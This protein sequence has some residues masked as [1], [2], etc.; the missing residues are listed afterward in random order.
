M[1]YS[2]NNI[3]QYS[4]FFTDSRVSALGRLATLEQITNTK[5]DLTVAYRP[6][7]DTQ[8]KQKRLPKESPLII[9]MIVYKVFLFILYCLVD[10]QHT[11]Y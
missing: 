5:N 1:L 11:F 8:H 7:R 2:V 6:T 10:A 9:M 3:L 4:G